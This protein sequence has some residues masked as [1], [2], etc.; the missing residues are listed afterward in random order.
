[1]EC[2]IITVD[3]RP[4]EECPKLDCGLVDAGY[5]I[6]NHIINANCKGCS[7]SFSANGCSG[8]RRKDNE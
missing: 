3:M 5:G 8:T 2:E 7:K 1:M 4:Y 6:V